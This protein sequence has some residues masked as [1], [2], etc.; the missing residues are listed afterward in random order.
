MNV[1][2]N[3]KLHSPYRRK[4]H[5]DDVTFKDVIIAECHRVDINIYNT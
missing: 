2:Q 1:V 5:L 3:K 4:S